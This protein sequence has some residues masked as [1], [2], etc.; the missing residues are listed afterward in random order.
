MTL[1]SSLALI[2]CYN[3]YS[4]IEIFAIFGQDIRLLLSYHFTQKTTI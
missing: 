1:F 4:F 3:N 2:C